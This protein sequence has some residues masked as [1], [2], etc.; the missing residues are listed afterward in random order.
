MY[1]RTGKKQKPMRLRDDDSVSKLSLIKFCKEA[2]RQ[3]HDS[4]D[5]DAALRFE[6]LHDYLL[7]DFRGAYLTYTHKALGL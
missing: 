2:A 3:L 6:I 5:P 7:H 1:Q 4:K